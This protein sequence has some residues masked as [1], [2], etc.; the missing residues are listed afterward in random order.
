MPVETMMD[1]DDVNTRRWF[2]LIQGALLA[3]ATAAFG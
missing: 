1:R 2:R 3:A